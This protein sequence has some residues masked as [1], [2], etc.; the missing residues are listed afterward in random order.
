MLGAPSRFTAIV[1]KETL[2]RYL[3]RPRTAIK[4]LMYILRTSGGQAQRAV[5]YHGFAVKPSQASVQRVNFHESDTCGVV[6][7]PH[8]RG[9][10]CRGKQRDNG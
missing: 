2:N 9:V 7:A 1:L 8:N 10:V 4:L 3:P 6:Y 5:P